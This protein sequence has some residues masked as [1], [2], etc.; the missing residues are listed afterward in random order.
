MKKRINFLCA[1]IMGDTRVAHKAFIEV[2]GRLQNNSSGNKPVRGSFE[3]CDAGRSNSSWQS[4]SYDLEGRLEL[5]L[6]CRGVP[7]ISSL[8]SSLEARVFQM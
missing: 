4:N 6:L 7:S 8:R 3:V 5:L 1:Q 2:F